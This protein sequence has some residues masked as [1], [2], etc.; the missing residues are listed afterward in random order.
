MTSGKLAYLW[1]RVCILTACKRSLG[2]GNFFTAVCH[3]FC[4]RKGEGGF[5]ACITATRSGRSASR[6]VKACLHVPSPSLCP[7]PSKFNIMPMVMVHL[8]GRMGTE[9]ILSIKWSVSIDATINFDGDGDKDGDGTCK[10][11]FRQT[12]LPP[13]VIYMRYG[14]QA[15]GTHPTGCDIIIHCLSKPWCHVSGWSNGVFPLPDSYADSY[16]DSYLGIMQKGYTRTDSN[17]HSD[18][19]LLWQLL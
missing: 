5:P 10:Q 2:Q 13:P 8:M 4:P 9:P 19:K 14:Q 15:G 6:G 18:A 7:S 12:P 3:S 17:G 11:A 16:S 1:P